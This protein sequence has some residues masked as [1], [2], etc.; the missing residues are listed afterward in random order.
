MTAGQKIATLRESLGWTRRM[1]ASKYGTSTRRVAAAEGDRD[2]KPKNEEPRH[3]MVFIPF[4]GYNVHC[5][6][7]EPIA[8][9]NFDLGQTQSKLLLFLDGC[10]QNIAII[11]PV[12]RLFKAIKRKRI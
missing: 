5:F 12:N 4:L 10:K 2:P 9:R 11:A 8:D 1:L 3:R 6:S 7:R